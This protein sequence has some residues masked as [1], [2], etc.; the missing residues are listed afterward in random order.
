MS[1][2]WYK[3]YPSNWL[4]SEAR[5]RMSPSERSIYRDLLDICY[6][7]GSI[8]DDERT[9]AGLSAVSTIEFRAAWPEVSKKFVSVGGG[10]LSNLK[11]IEELSRCADVTAARVVAGIA[12][13]RK[14]GATR[15]AK[16]TSA[17]G[18]SPAIP[19]APRAPLCIAPVSMS[20]ETWYSLAFDSFI[21]RYPN[22]VEVDLTAQTWLFLVEGG[23]I[24][25]ASL[26]NLNAGLD[27][28]I[29]SDQWTREDGRFVP[30]PV[31][32]LRDKRWLDHPPASAETKIERRGAKR[33]GDGV[34]PNAEWIPDW[35]RDVA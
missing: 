5:M 21:D 26:P 6:Q 2:P 27:R 29:E 7:E 15:A 4:A 17:T 31:K 22:R 14:S 18:T 28:W 25:E 34:D 10:R 35:K 3:W 13:G 32:W 19:V 12:G 24:T 11:C 23:V 8:P 30:S 33:S 9:L 16:A 1:R 20:D